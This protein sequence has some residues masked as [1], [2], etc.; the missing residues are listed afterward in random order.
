[1]TFRII[2]I[3]SCAALT[4]V[5]SAVAAAAATP[6]ITDTETPLHSLGIDP[7]LYDACGFEVE[8]LNEGRVRTIEYTDGS[9]LRHSHQTFLWQA[10]GLTLR[11]PRELL[12]HAGP[13]RVAH[14]PWHGLQP[15]RARSRPCHRRGGDRGIRS[16]RWSR[17]DRRPTP[18]SGRP[19]ECRSGLQ[20]LRERVAHCISQPEVAKPAERRASPVNRPR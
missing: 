9:A 17:S 19:G 18:G 2:V 20:L 10:N 3:L 15:A 16:R 6:V 1:M 12:D 7:M 5:T 11:E 13:E 8:V 4:L 14:L